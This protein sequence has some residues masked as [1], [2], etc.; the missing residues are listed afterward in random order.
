M[1]RK[2]TGT[3][4]INL[5]DI[6]EHQIIA[7]TPSGMHTHHVDGTR[8]NN[9]ISNLQVMTPSNHIKLHAGTLGEPNALE[10][11]EV[12]CPNCHEKRMIQYRC[13]K[14][15]NYTGLCKQCNWTAKRNDYWTRTNDSRIKTG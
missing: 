14:R 11:I 2:R 13:T 8:R 12:E 6:R 1:G 15:G 7:N 5:G 4:Y 9:E 10:Y 3:N